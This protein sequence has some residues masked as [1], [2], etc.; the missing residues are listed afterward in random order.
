MAT[1]RKTAK[2]WRKAY[3]DA[4][5][6]LKKTE[7]DIKQRLK[8]LIKAHPDAVIGM[9]ANT[10]RTEIKASSL[11]SEYYLNGMSINST[12]Q[13]IEIIEQY[14][15]DQ[16]PHQQQALFV[17]DKAGDDPKPSY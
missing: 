11:D 13:Y 7:N 3:H 8:D 12:I 17:T 2:D 15:A 10:E 4:E 1:K 5:L 16:H 14:L 9:K 6:K